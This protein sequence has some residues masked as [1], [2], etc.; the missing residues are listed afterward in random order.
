MI[1]FWAR[2]AHPSTQVVRIW[3][4]RTAVFAVGLGATLVY[5]IAILLEATK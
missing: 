2:V 4:T 1:F 5:P 3:G